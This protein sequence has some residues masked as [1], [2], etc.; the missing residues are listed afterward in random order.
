MPSFISKDEATR[1]DLWSCTQQASG[2]VLELVT[3]A[4]DLKLVTS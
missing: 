4:V 2:T 1:L 3:S